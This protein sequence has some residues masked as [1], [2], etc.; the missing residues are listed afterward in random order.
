MKKQTE[1]IEERKN[2]GKAPQIKM[3]A[4]EPKLVDIDLIYSNGYNPN[5]V[6]KPEL[7]LLRLSIEQNGFCF[8]IVVMDD[9]KG[10]Y[11]I[12]DGYHR[13]ITMRDVLH[14]KQIPVVILDQPIGMRVTATVQ[15]NRAR[16]THQIVDMS[17]LVIKLVKSGMPDDEIM[18]RLGMEPDELLR[19]KQISGIKEAFGNKQ[20]AKS[21]KEFVA[22]YP[23]GHDDKITVSKIKSGEGNAETEFE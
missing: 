16:G 13:W 6:Y 11:C 17:K 15:F 21:W 4:M 5:R 2:G 23:D 9:G 10:R 12:I 8:P 18:E 14:Q 1:N 22:K 3:K 19:L 20:F 7:D